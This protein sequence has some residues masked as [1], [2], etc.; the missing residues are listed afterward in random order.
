MGVFPIAMNILQF[1]LIDSI[2]KFKT[3]FVDDAG[4]S[5]EDREPLVNENFENDDDEDD[6]TDT[7]R[8]RASMDIERGSVRSRNS[9]SASVSASSRTFSNSHTKENDDASSSAPTSSSSRTVVPRRR[10]PPP[11]PSHGYTPSSSYGS[12]GADDATRLSRE[13]ARWGLRE[14]D[15]DEHAKW[16]RSLGQDNDADS[17]SGT[18]DGRR[19]SVSPAALKQWES[20]N[21][22][23]ISPP[24]K[25]QPLR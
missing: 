14:E 11:E 25:D 2:V 10:S 21:M 8:P 17:A 13:R 7:R 3:T 15:D 4:P 12:I 9:Y 24:I 6:S 20:W 5:S 18:E 1:W 19:R 22:P 23:V 16:G